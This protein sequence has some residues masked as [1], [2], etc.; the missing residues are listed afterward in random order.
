MLP[1]A[2]TTAESWDI[3]TL[4]GGI[5]PTESRPQVWE[6]ISGLDIRS[7]V[8]AMEYEAM[9]VRLDQGAL[10][11][12]C[13]GDIDRDVPRVNFGEPLSQ[14]ALQRVLKAFCLWHPSVCY[15]QPLCFIAGFLLRCLNEERAF[16]GLI[17]LHISQCRGYWTRGMV[18]WKVDEQIL[19]EYIR[20]SLPSVHAHLQSNRVQPA[21]VFTPWLQ[22]LFVAHGEPSDCERLWDVMLAAGV[23]FLHA[24]AAVLFRRTQ[25]ALLQTSSAPEMFQLF[26][27]PLPPGEI[28]HLVKEAVAIEPA[29][30]NRYKQVRIRLNCPDRIASASCGAAAYRARRSV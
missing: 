17:Q 24:V 23:H 4:M 30:H 9:L 16:Y 10:S 6:Q 11:A 15:C 20:D 7:E 5:T 18:G 28:D 8:Y 12:E 22:T 26:A 13:A 3:E 14:P 27:R 1:D 2:M 21:M 19:G 29:I 25:P